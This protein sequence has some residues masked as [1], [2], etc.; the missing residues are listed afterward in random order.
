MGAEE[1]KRTVVLPEEMECM[2]CGY[3]WLPRKLY[4]KQCPNCKSQNWN[5][6]RKNNTRSKDEFK[7]NEE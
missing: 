1:E 7:K 6:P 3:T 2:K 5:L 4:I